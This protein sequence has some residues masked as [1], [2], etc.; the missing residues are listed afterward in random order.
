M[1]QISIL[2]NVDEKQVSKFLGI[3]SEKVITDFLQAIKSQQREK[4]FAYIDEISQSG[5]DLYHFTKQ[6]V[7]YIDIHLMEDVDNY[8]QIAKVCGEILNNI[9]QYPYPA[10]VYK[11]AYNNYI[12]PTNQS[13]N[14]NTND[15]NNTPSTP[16]PQTNTDTNSTIN[17]IETPDTQEE[18]PNT[19]EQNDKKNTPS[20]ETDIK[21]QILNKLPQGLLK[22]TISKQTDI[23]QIDDHTIQITTISNIANIMLQKA[24]NIQHIEQIAK[25]LY[26]KGMQIKV[27]LISKDDYLQ[28]AMQ[29][30]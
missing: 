1:D 19:I 22:D 9:R 11:I 18:T 16:I 10:I 6:I 2:G 13:N 12:N 30:Q 26:Q 4:I 17:K 27:S 15:T 3:A 23:Q 25:E 21:A 28:T 5:I 29:Q 7:Q 24:E 20:T 8:L 14:Q